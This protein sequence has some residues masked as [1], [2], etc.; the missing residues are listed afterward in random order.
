MNITEYFSNK[1]EAERKMLC[2]L[3][4]T[5]GGYEEERILHN[6]LLDSYVG[7]GGFQNGLIPAPDAP[8]WGRRAYERGRSAWINSRDRYMLGQDGGEKRAVQ[9]KASY[10]VAFSG[11]DQDAYR[12]RIMCASYHN[13]VEKIVRVTNSLLFQQEPQRNNIPQALAGW[14]DKADSRQRSMSHSMR[15]TGLRTQIFGWTGVLVDSPADIAPEQMTAAAMAERMPYVVPLCPQEIL[16][17]DIQ[18]SGEVTGLKISTMHEHRRTSMMDEKLHEEHITYLYPDRWERYVILMPPPKYAK[19]DG[20]F[21]P[22]TGRIIS[23]TKGINYHGRIP[24]EFCSWD[25][26]FGVVASSGLPQIYNIAKVAWDL[27]QQNSELRNIMRGQTFAQLIK[28]KPMGVGPGQTSVGIGNYLTEDESS[29]GITRY[30]NPSAESANVYE[31]RMEGTTEMLHA[32]SGLDLNSRRY[33][34]TAEAMRIRFQ[35]T[36]SMLRNAAKNLE[37]C[38]RNLIV[39]AG[40]AMSFRESVLADIE[41]IRP[42]VFDVDRY[43]TQIDESLKGLALP[44]GPEAIKSILRRTIRSLVPSSTE[45][46]L[47]MLDA[48]I[49]TTV[50]KSYASIHAAALNGAAATPVTAQ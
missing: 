3:R 39:I 15:N 22:D 27:F 24:V 8:F 47:N 29:K 5:R 36:S 16:D 23:E 46:D 4:S 21:E 10:L 9:N 1:S 17:I 45:S 2:L 38:E 19:G 32:I 50:D 13:P 43:S 40:R 41:V 44:W 28:P 35:Q 11:E 14:I 42:T 49:S 37:V 31:K 6:F 26:G 30:I 33:T 12:D 18:P 7:G 34:E 48:E 25:E 20:Y